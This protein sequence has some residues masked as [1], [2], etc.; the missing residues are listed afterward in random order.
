MYIGRT[1]SGRNFNDDEA[2]E[3]GEDSGS[4]EEDLE[5]GAEEDIGDSGDFS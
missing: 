1:Q 5:E 2:E 4:G 3:G